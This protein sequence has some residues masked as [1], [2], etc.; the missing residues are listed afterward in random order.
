MIGLTDVEE[1]VPVP[2]PEDLLDRMVRAVER[3]R[4]RLSR[5]TAALEEGGVPYA[6]VGGKRS[7]SWV[8]ASR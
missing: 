2:G 8:V 5:A 4:E 7:L 1:D 6:V 3:V